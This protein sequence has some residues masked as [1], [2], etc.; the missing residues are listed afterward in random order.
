LV[1]VLAKSEVKSKLED[2]SVIRHNLDVFAEVTGLPPDLK[3]K[4]NI[5]LVPGTHPIHKASYC[6]API[7]LRELKEKLQKF[8]DQDFI[9]L[10]VSSWGAPVLFVK[11]KDGSMRYCIDYRELNQVTIKNNYPSRRIDDLS[12]QLKGALIFWKI[13]LLL[14]YHQLKVREEDVPKTAIQTRYNHYKFLVMPFG[15]TNAS[16]VFIELMNRVFHE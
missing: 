9:C 4:F 8:L 16:L 13:D 14:G 15:M 5:D 3:I 10:S 12:N 11:K 6:M 2:I 1:Y 7:E